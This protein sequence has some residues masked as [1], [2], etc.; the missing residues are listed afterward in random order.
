[1][2]YE[3]VKSVHVFSM[4]LW[5]GPLLLVPLLLV[6][7]EA[8]SSLIPRLRSAFRAV[9]VPSMILSWITGITLAVWGGWFSGGWLHGKL[10]FVVLL[11]GLHGVVAGRLR[12]AEQG[13][14]VPG[15]FRHGA[16]M[17]M[18]LLAVVVVLVQ[19][20]PF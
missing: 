13:V 9:T 19:V 6:G 11:S 4:V 2:T 3:I 5:M 20:K 18:V 1:M 16:V 12:K 8:S 10:L 7:I 17:V 14:P 15:W